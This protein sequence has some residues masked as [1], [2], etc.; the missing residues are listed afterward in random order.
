MSTSRPSLPPGTVSATPKHG[1]MTASDFKSEL[2]HRLRLEGRQAR[3]QVE[4]SWGPKR[5][6]SVYVNFINLPAGVG[7]AGGG[8][9]GENNRASFWVRGFGPAS[10]PEASKVK[11]EQA[12]SSLYK[13]AG[14]PSRETRVVM[15]AKTGTP[16]QVAK[17]LADFLNKVVVEV[18]PR[19]THTERR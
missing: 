8:A 18:E 2:E 7:S 4:T 13:G 10:A 19:F 9:E 14:A 17:T 1:A 15:R 3:V 6:E 16:E 12:T 5:E 11:V